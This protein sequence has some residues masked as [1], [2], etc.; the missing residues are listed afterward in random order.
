MR[1]D[2]TDR[3][4]GTGRA[5]VGRVVAQG[6]LCLW[7]LLAAPASLPEGGPSG[8]ASA[9]AIQ[10]TL[11]EAVV[12][13]LERNRSFLDRRSDREVQKFSLV[14]AEDRWTPKL[15]LRPFVSQD[16]ADKKAGG[17]AEVNL[18]VPTGGTFNLRWDKVV[19]ENFEDSKS[20]AL[21]YS[22][23]LLRGAWPEID[24]ASVRQARLDERIAIL[25][26]RKSAEDLIV[27]VSGA[28]RALISAIRRVE[29]AE[30]S[31]RRARE[32]LVTARTLIQAGRVAQRET[33]R[34][35]VEIANREVSLTQAQNRLDTANFALADILEFE[36]DIPIRP[37]VALEVERREIVFEAAFE[38][39]LR[40]RPDFLQAQLQAE[41]AEIGLTVA[42]NN[43]LPDL[44][45][46]LEWRR[47]S[48]GETDTAVRV[49]A[50]IPLDDLDRDLRQL[51][52]HTALRKAKRSV[53]ELRESIGIAV[54][55]AIKDV[56]VRFRLTELAR[57]ARELAEESLMIEEQKFS[58]GLS[59]SFEVA[60]SGDVLIRAEQAEVEAII[61]YLDGL[62]RLDQ[63]SG[64]TLERWGIRLETETP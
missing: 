34:S 33:V 61:A 13:A 11:E 47:D 6:L 3:V 5:V 20:Q 41:I 19:S 23:P 4:A 12:L 60:E 51:Q 32:Q 63:I 57:S 52:A 17:G 18:R 28:Y 26:F 37:Q 59:S 2:S 25:S 38:E 53:V 9:G 29:I 42:R 50:S 39:A 43:L 58:Q 8:P 44:D 40:S 36:G 48:A 49:D 14:V 64:K 7:G 31:L 45:L 21:S 22:Q 62:T 56:E 1:Q 27:S 16:E 54:R 15:N 24:T 10:L 46:K 55:E 30:N 35:E